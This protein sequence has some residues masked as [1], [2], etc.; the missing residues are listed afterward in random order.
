MKGCG[1]RAESIETWARCPWR[2]AGQLVACRRLAAAPAE[3]RAAGDRAAASRK[4]WSRP[5]GARSACRTCPISVLAF[6][7]EKM[8]AQG[9][10]NIDDLARLSPGLNFQRNGMSSSGNYNDEGSDINI[11]GVDSTGGHLDH[12]HL[13]RRHADPDATPRFRLD[14]CL[15]GALR[16]GPGRG[17]ARPAGHAVR[18]RRRGRRGALHHARARV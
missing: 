1:M 18:R 16:S 12:R 8:D 10:K 6:S 5:R 15:P 17:A 4:S 14:Q 13:H 2:L 9:L 7:Q 11:R 3:P